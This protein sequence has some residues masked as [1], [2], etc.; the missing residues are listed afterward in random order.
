M[1]PGFVTPEYAVTSS[2]S[3]L[4]E[5]DFARTIKM[6][7]LFAAEGSYSE[8]R[9]I[10][11]DLLARDPNNASIRSKL[12]AIDQ[13]EQASSRATAEQESFTAPDTEY[14]TPTTEHPTSTT[15]HPPQPRNP[16]VEKLEQWLAR[17]KRV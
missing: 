9:D 13:A 6:A 5:A 12:D 7:D 15:A 14:R 2:M 17:V 16:K 4:D 1:A 3:P 11:E 10:Y 8:A